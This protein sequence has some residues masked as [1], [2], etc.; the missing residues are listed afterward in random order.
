MKGTIII[1]I[2]GD[3]QWELGERLAKYEKIFKLLINKGALDGIRGGSANLHFD[4][5]ANFAGLELNYWPYREK[6]K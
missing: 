3:N 2:E 6:K 4:G 5:E 1:E